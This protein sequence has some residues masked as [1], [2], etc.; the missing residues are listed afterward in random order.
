[1]ECS[2]FGAVEGI[3]TPMV[4][5]TDLNRARLPIPPR[6]HMLRAVCSRNDY[7]TITARKMQAGICVF[8]DAPTKLCTVK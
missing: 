3:R 8:F 7:Y 4:S 1:M 5:H 2:F 6:P